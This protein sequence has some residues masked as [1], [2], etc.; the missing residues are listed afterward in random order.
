M[1]GRTNIVMW[2]LS[3]TIDLV[4]VNRLEMATWML[5]DVHPEL[6]NVIATKLSVTLCKVPR[7]VHAVTHKVMESTPRLLSVVCRVDV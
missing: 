5:K 2:R 3:R 4:V 7:L 1:R 6:V